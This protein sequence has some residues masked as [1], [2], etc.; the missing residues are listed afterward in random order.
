MSKSFNL[1]LTL[2]CFI[3]LLPPLVSC[4]IINFEELNISSNI[5][6]DEIYF[7]KNCIK[8]IFSIPPSA[9]LTEKII[10]LKEDDSKVDLDFKWNQS[11]CEIKPQ[12]GFKKNSVYNFKICGTLITEDNRNYEIDYSRI[13]TYGTENDRFCLTAY[14]NPDETAQNKNLILTFNKPV[15]IPN[16][17][18][19]FSISPYI[20]V[21]KTYSDDNKTITIIPED[22]WTVN[23]YY[24][25]LIKSIDSPEGYKTDKEYTRSFYYSHDYVL[26]QLV[27]SN[28][29]DRKITDSL[30]FI[31]N[32]KINLESFENNFSISP[33]I[34]G[35]FTQN[36]T[37]V[38]F[39]SLSNF[40]INK[41]YIIYLPSKICDENNLCLY[42]DIYKTFTPVNQFLTIS[43]ISI[44]EA[45]NISLSNESI[46]EIDITN[47]DSFF[48][49]I[50]FSSPIK[51]ENL[52]SAEKAIQIEPFFPA[53]TTYPKLTSA[54]WNQER[55]KLNLTYSNISKTYNN[56]LYIITV[57]NSKTYFLTEN[58]E[59]MEKDI[60]IHFLTKQ[61]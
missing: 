38:T 33:Y 36:E 46:S 11:E 25:W 18:D 6:K 28:L 7:D 13:F 17:E 9:L 8:I 58:E 52:T 43:S 57:S 29:N 53:S 55:T 34:K 26:P 3:T 47:T 19:N 30:S 15:D 60:C 16:F 54:S 39:H 22:N 31:F 5:D 2:L 42:S 59:Y 4:S 61:N 37:T 45:Q 35:Y 21:S 56:Q 49:E 44:N 27:S 48:I 1:T 10:T 40:E 14:S 12:T 32:K 41:E 50:I 51:K 20:K 23:T 24:T